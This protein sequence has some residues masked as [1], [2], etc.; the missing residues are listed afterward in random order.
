MDIKSIMH[1]NFDM[2]LNRD[3][4]LSKISQMSS[5]L[6][7]H[8]KKFKKDAQKLKLSMWLR[9]YATWIAVGILLLFI[10]Y[11]KFYVF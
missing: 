4:N 1:E 11:I 9:Q 3:K 8:S 6:K 5:D 7:D 10:L 2:I